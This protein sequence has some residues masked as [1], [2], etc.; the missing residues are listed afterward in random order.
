MRRC[1]RVRWRR[2]GAGGGDPPSAL[3]AAAPAA[4]ELRFCWGLRSP[5]GPGREGSPA[6]LARIFAW[7][8]RAGERAGRGLCA[9]RGLFTVLMAK[10]GVRSGREETASAPHPGGE[11]TERCGLGGQ[12]RSAGPDEAGVACFRGMLKRKGHTGRAAGTIHLALC[13]A[14]PST[15][16]PAH[17]SQHSKRR[18]ARSFYYERRDSPICV[19]N[20]PP[21]SHR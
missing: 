3:L 20:K 13:L 1:A 7:R 6:G 11:A 15:A 10:T 5:P 17:S 2:L 9:A 21:V 18:S 19:S 14:A 12:P 4:E 8:S 16:P